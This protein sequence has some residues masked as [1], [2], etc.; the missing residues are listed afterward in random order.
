[1]P[2]VLL[3][4]AVIERHGSPDGR[5]HSLALEVIAERVSDSRGGSTSNS[6]ES[7]LEHSFQVVRARIVKVGTQPAIGAAVPTL[8]PEMHQPDSKT[9]CRRLIV[10]DSPGGRVGEKYRRGIRGYGGARPSR[11]KGWLGGLQET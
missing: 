1:M 4:C 2:R 11:K 9:L 5:F 3:S 6:G 8:E 10:Q 7:L